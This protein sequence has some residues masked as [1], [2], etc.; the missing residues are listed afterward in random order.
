MQP[1]LVGAPGFQ[2][3]FDQAGNGGGAGAETLN[4]AVMSDGMP[5]AI[6]QDG[7]FFTILGGPADIAFDPAI[8]GRGAAADNGAVKPLD[9]MAGKLFGQRVMRSVILDHYNQSAGILVDTVDNTGALDSTDAGQACAAMMD[10]GIDQGAGKIAG[11]GMDNQP[12][13]FINNNQII[14]FIDHSQRNVLALWFGVRGIRH[15]NIKGLPGLHF[16][17]RIRHRMLFGDN[18]SFLNQLPDAAAGEVRNP[19]GEKFIKADAPFSF[20]HRNAKHVCTGCHRMKPM[21]KM[22]EPANDRHVPSRMERIMRIVVIVL[23]VILFVGFV[24]V[25]GTIAYRIANPDWKDKN[26]TEAVSAPPGDQILAEM[27]EVV[28]PG[29]AELVAATGSGDLLYLHFRSGD[30]GDRIIVVSLATGAVRA[31][32]AVRDP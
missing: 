13:G 5:A 10:Q 11:A 17:G 12:G 16:I 2:S 20:R 1:D 8:E 9:G 29:G 19:R 25:I 15:K 26:T 23:G 27:V 7:H 22:S 30:E 6:F 4:G 14:V 31:T 32:V 18:G 3:A 24:F 28:R 21:Q